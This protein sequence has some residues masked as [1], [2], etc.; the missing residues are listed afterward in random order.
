VSDQIA[1]EQPDLQRCTQASTQS[2]AK[3]ATKNFKRENMRAYAR[4]AK[5]S[6]NTKS[7][8]VQDIND[9]ELIVDMY[10]VSMT[11]AK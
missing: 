2:R 3:S 9:G 1:I 7:K 6:G 5:A 11:I 4:T 8:F 10:H